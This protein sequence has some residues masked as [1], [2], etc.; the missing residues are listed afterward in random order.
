MT[1]SRMAHPDLFIEKSS[2]VVKKLLKV[3]FDPFH[4]K[5]V[6]K[7]TENSSCVECLCNAPL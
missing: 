2:N 7:V 3:A 5:L 1:R 6:Q 4:C